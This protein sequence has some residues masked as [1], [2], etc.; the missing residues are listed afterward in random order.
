MYSK[1]MIQGCQH[2]SI[3]MLTLLD[4]LL[5]LAKQEKLTFQLNKEYFNL[6][7]AV[8]NSFK[9]L[10]FLSQKKKIKLNLITKYEQQKFFKQIYGDQKRY[11]QIL[12]NF[13]SNALKFSNENSNVDIIINATKIFEP[14]NSS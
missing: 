4:D 13:I 7:N 3:M 5:D 11:E 12:L 8:E 6:I 2:S 10:E 14:E 1:E 9:T